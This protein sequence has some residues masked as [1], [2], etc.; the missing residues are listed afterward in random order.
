MAFTIVV[1]MVH[2]GVNNPFLLCMADSYLSVFGKIITHL[3]LCTHVSLLCLING[4]FQR[5]IRV[6]FS[7][8]LSLIVVAILSDAQETSDIAI[9]GPVVV[10][11]EFLLFRRHLL[12]CLFSF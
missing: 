2:T 4:N 12:I 3:L 7:L 5:H 8:V 11:P 6:F 9:V 10:T 1:Y